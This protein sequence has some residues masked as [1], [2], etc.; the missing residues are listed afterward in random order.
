VQ[1]LK[2]HDVGE[3]ESELGTDF[4]YFSCLS[5]LKLV[6]R[7][8]RLSIAGSTEVL[9]RTSSSSRSPYL[10][11]RFGGNDVFSPEDKQRG[12][13]IILVVDIFKG[14][15]YGLTVKAF[16]LKLVWVFET[17]MGADGVHT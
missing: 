10:A 12:F 17:F 5:G 16:E 4:T 3:R 2:R 9:C 11:G 14:A 7:L 15:A 13:S 8:P 6:T 1:L